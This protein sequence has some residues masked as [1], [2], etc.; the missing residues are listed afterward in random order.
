MIAALFRI[1]YQGWSKDVA[2][3]EMQNGNFGFHAVWGNIPRYI[4]NANV[5]RLKRDVGVP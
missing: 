1:V 3:D 4:R 5:E 2:L